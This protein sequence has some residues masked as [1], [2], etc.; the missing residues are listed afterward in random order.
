MWPQVSGAWRLLALVTRVEVL[1]FNK[2]PPARP[3]AP[4][5][6]TADT[7]QHKHSTNTAQTQAKAVVQLTVKEVD[8]HRKQLPTVKVALAVL[9]NER[10]RRPLHAGTA[11]SGHHL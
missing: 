6:A 3:A 2:R 8:L 11:R 9:A 4:V 5:E 7:S 10:S 1:P